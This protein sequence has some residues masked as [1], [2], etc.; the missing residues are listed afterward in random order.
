M[1]N[2]KGTG[3]AIITP[4]KSDL[5]IDFEA[6]KK[7]ITHCIDGGVNYLVVLGTTGEGPTLTKEEKNAVYEFV[8]NE[9]NGRIQIVYGLGGNNTAEIVQQ[10]KDGT[11]AKY[12]AILSVSPYYNKP[13]QEGIYQHY[14]AIATHTNKP[15]ILYNVPGR[16]ASNLTAETT[17]RLA[18][19][20]KNIIAIKEASGNLEQMMA[21]LLGNKRADFFVTC[22]DDG[23]TLP[24][25]ALGGCGVIS[26]LG[27]V[28]PKVISG[29]VNAALSG[30][31]EESKT[32]H[33]NALPIIDLLFK[34]GN[35]V[36]VKAYLNT[37]GICEEF[38]RL[39]LIAASEDL[40]N[41]IKEN[42]L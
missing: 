12:D 15:I 18:N 39:P 37:L 32:L 21:I 23:L 29:L 14:K 2:V 7:I 31:F 17:L 16:T 24:L 1:F 30:N 9:V 27:N 5:S 40:K 36:G 35:P 26:V 13:S 3:V 20:F 6:L 38:V 28:Y 4:F 10:L 11:L 42:L 22:G 33:Y 19:D 34:E 41:S 8:Y 25:I